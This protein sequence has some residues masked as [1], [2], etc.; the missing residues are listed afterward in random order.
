[1]SVQQEVLNSPVKKTSVFTKIKIG[2]AVIIVFFL[3]IAATV[4]ILYLTNERAKSLI[5]EQIKS[6]NA[7]KEL[8]EKAKISSDTRISEL[9]IGRAHV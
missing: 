4:G 7:Q 5:D 1:M 3:V 2:I 6:Y 8:E 9:E